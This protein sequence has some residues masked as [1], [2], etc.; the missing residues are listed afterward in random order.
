MHGLGALGH[1]VC[2]QTG[3]SVAGGLLTVTDMAAQGDW[4]PV[5][6]HGRGLSC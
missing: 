1:D 2:A 5:S 3:S 4:H 6:S